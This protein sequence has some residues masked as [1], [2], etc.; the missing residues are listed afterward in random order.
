MVA[1]CYDALPSGRASGSTS[2]TVMV[3]VSCS[4]V[5]SE[6]GGAVYLYTIN[7]PTYYQ[8]MISESYT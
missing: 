2:G 1:V 8:M 7:I 3:S 6:R 5:F 4:G